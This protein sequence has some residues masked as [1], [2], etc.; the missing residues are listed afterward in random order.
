LTTSPVMLGFGPGFD[1]EEC[2]I[3]LM[4]EH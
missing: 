4:L 2:V 3:G 1:V